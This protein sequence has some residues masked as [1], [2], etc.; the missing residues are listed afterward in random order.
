MCIAAVEYLLEKKQLKWRDSVL[1]FAP[2]PHSRHSP[3]H[4][5]VLSAQTDES[6]TARMRFTD[7]DE[8]QF[9]DTV[10]KLT[11][12]DKESPSSVVKKM[13]PS[14][15]MEAAGGAL[16]WHWPE[17]VCEDVSG[18]SIAEKETVFQ[19]PSPHTSHQASLVKPN[20]IKDASHPLTDAGDQQ[21]MEV[22]TRQISALPSQKL[23][24]L[25][26]LLKKKKICKQCSVKVDLADETVTLSGTGEDILSAELAVYEALASASECCLNI[27]E[28][29]GHLLT[30]PK[31]Q[32]WFDEGCERGS[33]FGICYVHNSVTKLLTADDGN[34][35]DI[36]KWLSDA[37]RSER[38]SFTPHHVAFLR[39][40]EWLDCVRKLTDSHLLVITEDASEIV[41]LVEGPTDAVKMAVKEISDLLNR[42]CHVNKKISL[43]PADFRT[44]AFHCTDVVNKVQELRLM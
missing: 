38:V 28:A 11:C 40:R 10:T 35:S 26:K 29:L 6:M 22:I 23:K 43:K 42:V 41:I 3:A 24:F 21:K 31:G 5:G 25:K 2:K 13:I 15:H 27:S 20:V 14:Q 1:R 17:T 34:L 36:R 8:E 9:Y 30:S 32:Q 39:T 4:T 16:A 12:S 33:F 37:L 44:L 7:E 18:R 19:D